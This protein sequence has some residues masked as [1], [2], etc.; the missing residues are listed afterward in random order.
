MAKLERETHP[1]SMKLFDQPGEEE[2][3]W[4]VRESGLGATAHEPGGVDTWPGWEDSAVPPDRV[5]DY[6]A[7]LRRLYDRF[8][9]EAALYGHFGQGCIHTRINFDLASHDGI[10][11]FR[12]FVEEASSVVLSYGGSLSGEHGDGQARAELLPKM[13]GDEIVAAFGE[14]KAIW[15]PHDR[16]N[17]G[18]V[19][20]PHPLD[21]QLRIGTDYAPWEPV[22]FFE[23]PADEHSFAR[24][25][26]LRCVGVGKCRRE[27]GGTMCPSYMVTREEK[28]STRGRA[29]LLFEMMQRDVITDGWRSDAVRDALDLCLACKGCF[30]D[31]PV[32]VDMATY[33]AEFLAHHYAGRLRPAS[34]YSMGWL[35]IA[36]KGAALAPR[37]VNAIT[38]AP[39]LRAAVKRVGG[40]DPQ[41]EL[42]RFA[43]RTM[44][45][46]LASR[47]EHRDGPRVLLWPDT[48]TN[49]FDPDIGLAAHALLDDAGF[50]V[51]LPPANLCCG[52]TWISTGQLRTARR[53]LRR[54]LDALAPELR[55]GTPV[56]GLEPS[57][58]AVFRHDLHQL[59][60][61][62][63]D[64]DRLGQQTQ[65][66]AEL[67]HDAGSAWRPPRLSG[68]VIVQAH[69]HHA[70]VM[71]TGPDLE[72]LRS[73]GLDAE[74]LDAGCCGLAGNFGFER[75]HHDVSIACAERALLPAVRAA[76]Q[77]TTV[78]AD[79]FSCRTQIA[80]NSPRRAVHLAQLLA[81]GLRGSSGASA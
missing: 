29:R 56:V 76:P 16:M 61:H 70:A 47:L 36:A 3:I 60:P 6:L 68:H 69:C 30:G 23:Y 4:A 77:S 50:D 42:P 49:H 9:Y 64:A 58:T 65:T 51:V 44:R 46:Q 24:A 33:K 38:H 73:A 66:L 57:C 41:R 72:L 21:D 17:P 34:H 48:F 55:R 13:F 5:G 20:A 74:L 22:T 31:C 67:L 18:K 59:F 10:A 35:P 7:D 45:E 81:T 75:G 80:D 40:I 26:G 37:A 11:R 39:G 43:S 71:G 53:V 54:T 12:D 63:Q 25:G 2:K 79:G 19:V 1:P 78:L 62:D 27:G 14:F 8:G 15:D 28:H 32:N 52:L